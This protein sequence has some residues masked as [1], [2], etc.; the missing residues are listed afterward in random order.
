[1][2]RDPK[3]TKWWGFGKFMMGENLTLPNY[4]L[5]FKAIASCVLSGQKFFSILWN[6]AIF[7]LRSRV[8]LSTPRT[9]G[10]PYRAPYPHYSDYTPDGLRPNIAI[11]KL[12][13][14]KFNE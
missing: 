2:K 7:L 1:M 3:T 10:N 9:L 4:R 5:R 6:V 12:N 13:N 11:A 8:K 14:A